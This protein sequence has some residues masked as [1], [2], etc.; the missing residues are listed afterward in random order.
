MILFQVYSNM[1]NILIGIISL[2]FL[3]SCTMFNVQEGGTVHTTTGFELDA[4]DVTLLG[5]AGV[6]SKYPDTYDEFAKVA[7]VLHMMT[8]DGVI[9]SDDIK[10]QIDTVINES[11][12]SSTRKIAAMG[13]Y[14]LVLNYFENKYPLSVEAN[15]ERVDTVNAIA[16][17]TQYAL[18]LY[19]LTNGD[20]IRQIK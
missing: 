9:T 18:E 19:S 6:L 7:D 15:Q 2:C 17:A 4:Y 14:R 8:A 12:L 16:T 13:A 11:S 20:A 1:K 3:S 10:L 5:V